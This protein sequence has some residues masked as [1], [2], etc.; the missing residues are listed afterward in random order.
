MAAT[1]R[2]GK[3]RNLHH[4]GFAQVMLVLGLL[5]SSASAPGCS[6][7]KRKPSEQAG[8]ASPGVDDS[9]TSSAETTNSTK[10]VEKES[11]SSEQDEG[12]ASEPEPEPDVKFDLGVLPEAENSEGKELRPCEIDFLFVVDNS[13]SMRKEQE[14]LALAV[15]SFIDTMM[16]SEPELEKDYHIGVVTTDRFDQNTKD[17]RFLGGLVTAVEVQVTN[18][19]GILEWV[20]KECGPYQSGLNYM[21]QADDLGKTF[22]CAAQP[23]IIGSFEEK[24]IAALLGAVQP[25][26]GE[27]GQCNEGFV[28][29][30]ALLVVVLISDEDAEADT[31]QPKQWREELLALKGNDPRKLMMVSIV[32]PPDNQCDPEQGVV[33]VA[34]RIV[35]FTGLFGKRGFVGDICAPN[36]DGIFDKAVGMIDFACSELGEP[37]G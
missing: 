37:A 18:S 13:I 2:L 9:S 11:V 17:C 21:T 5:L 33:T 32:A 36:Y 7:V 34:E 20:R 3:F 15:P 12:E 26:R 25:E 28:R 19:E 30:E 16:K 22:T 14:S 6:Q 24:Q 23:G 29:K 8:G 1:K 35:E 4:F 27:S 10:S 31:G